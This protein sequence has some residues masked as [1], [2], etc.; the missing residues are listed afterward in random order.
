MVPDIPTAAEAGLPHFLVEVWMGLFVPKA[1]SP[2]VVT[3]LSDALGK[4]L[5]QPAVQRRLNEIGA[6][7]P[8]E[9]NRNGEHMLQRISNDIERWTPILRKEKK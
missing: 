3:T 5:G 2:L 4:A 7:I 8:E 6:Q 9:A 1:T